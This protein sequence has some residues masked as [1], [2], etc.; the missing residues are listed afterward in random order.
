M[1]DTLGVIICFLIGYFTPIGDYVMKAQN[2]PSLTLWL[3]KSILLRPF[4]C[5]SH[6]LH[7]LKTAVKTLPSFSNQF[8]QY[9]LRDFP[10]ECVNLLTDSVCS[11]SVYKAKG[12]IVKQN[13]VFSSDFFFNDIWKMPPSWF[14]QI[15]SRMKRLRGR[16]GELPR[17]TGFWLCFI[18]SP[19]LSADWERTGKGS[20]RQTSPDTL[21]TPSSAPSSLL[22]VYSM[23]FVSAASRFYHEIALTRCALQSLMKYFFPFFLSCNL[24][25]YY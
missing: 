22:G 25:L 20:N 19:A 7:A 23:S 24:K 21:L 6:F 10:K 16:K 5:A 18:F 12:Y 15:C 13:T 4:G 11:S 14:C 2:L 8:K 9:Y 3:I 17:A 1:A